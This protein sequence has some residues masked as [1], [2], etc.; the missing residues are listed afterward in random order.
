VR[1]LAVDDVERHALVRELQCVGVLQLVRHKAPTQPRAPPARR[2]RSART[3]HGVRPTAR[4]A[5][6]QQNSGPTGIA[7]RACSHG[8]RCSKPQPSMPGSRRWPPLPRRTSHRA[9]PRDD[10][11]SSGPS[12]DDAGRRGGS[13]LSRAR[14]RASAKTAGWSTDS[15]GLSDLR[16]PA[17]VVIFLY[18]LPREFWSK[19]R[20][21]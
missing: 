19:H 17:W 5:A 9:D 18:E 4:A 1:E 10:G 6:E 21:R 13:T 11:R 16:D 14:H 2:L 15:D 20:A 8:S 3:A 7:C 12:Q